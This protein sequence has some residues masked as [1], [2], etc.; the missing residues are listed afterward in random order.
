MEWREGRNGWMEGRNATTRDNEMIGYDVIAIVCLG[1]GEGEEFSEETRDDHWRNIFV[2]VSPYWYGMHT[3]A[4]LRSDGG[5][6]CW[7]YNN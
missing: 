7:T 2:D 3:C 6:M 5:M 1:N 4:V